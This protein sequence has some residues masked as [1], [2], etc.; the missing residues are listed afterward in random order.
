MTGVSSLAPRSASLLHRGR[1]IIRHASL[2]PEWSSSRRKGLSLVALE[3]MDHFHCLR[4]LSFTS[5]NHSSFRDSLT[6]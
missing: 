2:L 6:V 4:H 5:I 3:T 1:C